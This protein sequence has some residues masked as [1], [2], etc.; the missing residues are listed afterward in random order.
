M[1]TPGGEGGGWSWRS[2]QRTDGPLNT[3]V[4]ALRMPPSRPRGDVV[5]CPAMAQG[6]MFLALTDATGQV[7]I[8]AIPADGCGFR[9]AEVDRAIQG[10]TW[11]TIDSR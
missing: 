3:L 2:V 11:V 9:L 1:T 4:A 8:P 5:A 7:V 6:P 10:L